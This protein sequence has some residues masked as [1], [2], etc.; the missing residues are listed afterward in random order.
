MNWTDSRQSVAPW[1]Q[2]CPSPSGGG[3]PPLGAGIPSSLRRQGTHRCGSVLDAEGH[4]PPCCSGAPSTRCW[5]AAQRQVRYLPAAAARLLQ[6]RRRRGPRG[7]IIGRT[8]GDVLPV[9]NPGLLG[10]LTTC[11]T[12]GALLRA[13]ASAP[14]RTHAGGPVARGITR[15]LLRRLVAALARCR[16]RHPGRHGRGRGSPPGSSTRGAARRCCPRTAAGP[17]DTRRVTLQRPP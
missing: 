9:L 5:P 17:P 1:R 11:S 14:A 10:C 4:P 6:A 15:P 3:A 12:P 13:Q 2:C 16:G 7:A 8:W